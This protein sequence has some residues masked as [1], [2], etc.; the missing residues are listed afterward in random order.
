MSYAKDAKF[1]TVETFARIGASIE[2]LAKAA[3]VLLERAKAP[4]REVQ[5][6]RRQKKVA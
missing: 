4:T 3:P 1:D 2:L 6:P 5:G